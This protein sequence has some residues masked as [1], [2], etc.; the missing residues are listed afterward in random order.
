MPGELPRESGGHYGQFRDERHGRKAARNQSD[1]DMLNIIRAAPFGAALLLAAG[2][3]TDRQTD[4]PQ[5]ATE[6]LLV[7]KAVDRSVDHIGMS[8]PAGTKVF[9]DTQFF[10]ADTVVRPKYTISAVRDKLLHQGASLVDDRKAA[11]TVVELRSAAQSIDY[12]AF[13][14][15]IPSFPMPIPLAGTLQ[16]PEIAL[17]KVDKQKGV[18]DLAL[19]AYGQQN[20]SL[21][22][23]T[24]PEIGTS[25]KSKVVVLLV[26]WTADDVSPPAQPEPAPEAELPRP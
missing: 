21:I 2:C 22:A 6:Q 1:Q 18:S 17:F 26:S 10:D 16:F 24:G 12:S 4:P 20:G 5:T 7:T 9:L 23:S 15:G 8:F 13:L 19:T 11:D 3:A 14:I 25:L